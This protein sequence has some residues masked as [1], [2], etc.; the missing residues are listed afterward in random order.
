MTLEQLKAQDKKYAQVIADYLI[1]RCEIDKELEEKILATS[2]TLKGC[3]EYCKFEARKQ[4]EDNVAIIKDEEVYGWCV[5]YFLEDTIDFEKKE[6]VSEKKV[7]EPK[8]KKVETLFGEEEVEETT[9]KTVK[10]KKEKKEVKVQ[11]AEQ[12]SLFD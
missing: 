7:K 5:H 8:T 11:L 12:L 6:N 9:P 3:V 4:A 1:N 2:K 10:V